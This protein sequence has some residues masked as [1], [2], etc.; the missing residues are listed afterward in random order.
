MPRHDQTTNKIY[1]PQPH[2]N[3]DTKETLISDLR[4][5][6]HAISQAYEALKKTVPNMRNFYIQPDGSNAYQHA[7]AQYERRL[8]TL[9]FLRQE[10]T[11]EAELIQQNQV[12]G[13]MEDSFWEYEER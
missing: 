13:E 2:L 11:Y 5:A 8:R 4:D 7:R 1:C 6:F 3:G 9:N 12:Y 10:L